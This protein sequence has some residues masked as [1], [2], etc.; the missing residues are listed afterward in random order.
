MLKSSL[1]NYLGFSIFFTVLEVIKYASTETI[2]NDEINKNLLECFIYYIKSTEFIYSMCK[3]VGL[4]III[5]DSKD[6]LE[7]L[8]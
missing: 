2:I 3:L 1:L 6:T 7:E 8:L 4:S 5:S